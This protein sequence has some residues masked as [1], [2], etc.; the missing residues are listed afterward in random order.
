VIVRNFKGPK[1][2]ADQKDLSLAELNVLKRVAEE[3]GYYFLTS[4]VKTQ[5]GEQSFR[6]FSP[7]RS[8]L[9]S[10]LSDVLKVHLNPNGDIVAISYCMGRNDF[11]SLPHL[12]GTSRP[13]PQ[14]FNTT[15]TVSHGEPGPMPDTAPYL[16]KLEAERIAKERG[17]DPRDNRSFLAKYWMY[18]VPIALLVLLSGASNPEGEGGR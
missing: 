2:A 9:E 5:S 18:I 15:V 14:R 3:D 10:G 13:P 8:L 4:T 1:F 11:F 6:T 12:L 16:E 17:D 7:A